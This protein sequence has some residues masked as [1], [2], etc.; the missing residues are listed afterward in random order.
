ML[1]QNNQQTTP[2][3]RR[4]D[5]I[6]IPVSTFEKRLITKA[7]NNAG[8]ATASFCRQILLNHIKTVINLSFPN[9][10]ST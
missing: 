3:E 7:A 9:T 8:I 1:Q 6:V 10:I 2:A 5:Y 4:N